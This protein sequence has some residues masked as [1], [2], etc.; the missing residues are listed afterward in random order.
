MRGTAFGL[1]AVGALL[2]LLVLQV[3]IPG[4]ALPTAFVLIAS[5]LLSGR[6][7]V[8]A[9]FLS[10]LGFGF[11][12][13]WLKTQ[14]AD[15]MIG[16]VERSKPMIVALLLMMATVGGVRALG[17]KAAS[18]KRVLV[19]LVLIL[20]A[21]WAVAFLSGDSGGP[22]SMVRW[23]RSL[24]ASQE[25][26]MKL[27]LITRKSI[28]FGFYAAVAGIT[29]AAAARGGESRRTAALIA[30]GFAFALAAFDEMR[31]TGSS[32]RSGAA[33]D[34]LLDLSGAVTGAL[35][36]SRRQRVS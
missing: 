19:P 15:Q 31:Q 4:I 32:Y 28:H 22:N 29:S 1:G 36:A 17:L 27:T 11:V 24:G 35:I 13:L 14:P 25:L 3:A 8:P 9:G 18:L 16:P 2:L 26:S 21:V 20:L 33:R 5:L 12:A 10:A 6:R 7:W 34:V 30:I 23:F